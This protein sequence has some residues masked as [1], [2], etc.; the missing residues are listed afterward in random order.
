V[1]GSDPES[2][3]RVRAAADEELPEIVA[4]LE[5]PGFFADRMA[6]QRAG[7]GV[8]LIAWSG[9][10]PIGDVYVRLEPA[11]EP[12]LRQKLPDVPLL[13][14][15]EVLPAYRKQGVGSRLMVEAEQVAR[16]SGRD[17]IALGVTEDNSDALR[18]YR[19]RGYEPGDPAQI[20]T[21]REI[22]GDD[23]SV[24]TVPDD[25]CLIFIR[26]LDAL[27]GR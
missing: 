11:D 5:Q 25:P 9:D 27:P 18:L 19:R 6:R 21:Y 22:Y 13:T 2:F 15:L 16:S 26:R 4:S 14:H 24:T 10:T 17:R 12:A 8:L 23:G 20:D 7:L 1:A 3:V